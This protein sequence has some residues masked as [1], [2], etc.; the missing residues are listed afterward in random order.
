MLKDAG[1][2]VWMSNGTQD[3]KEVA[4]AYTLTNE[5]D[6]VAVYLNTHIL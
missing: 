1:V 4:N 6:G 2:G 5:E 3:A